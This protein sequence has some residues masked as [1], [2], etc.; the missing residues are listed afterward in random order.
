MTPM[1]NNYTKMFLE[2]KD[3]QICLDFM[4]GQCIPAIDVLKSN[5]GSN[6]IR[7]YR[8]NMESSR[9]YSKR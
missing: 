3:F 9:C 5:I 7:I 1:T 8:Y 2:S 6:K 4:P